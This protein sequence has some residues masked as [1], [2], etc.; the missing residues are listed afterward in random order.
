MHV[1]SPG[2]FVGRS[3]LLIVRT[4]KIPQDNN[5]SLAVP[6][7]CLDLLFSV[8]RHFVIS[9]AGL[10][11]VDKLQGGPPYGI[12]PAG[13]ECSMYEPSCGLTGF[14]EPLILHSISLG[15]LG[16]FFSVRGSYEIEQL[17]PSKGLDMSW[18][19]CEVNPCVGQEPASIVETLLTGS[20]FPL[21]S[22]LFKVCS[23]ESKSIATV[24][25]LRTCLHHKVGRPTGCLEEA[26]AELSVPPQPIASMKVL[27]PNVSTPFLVVGP[28][29]GLLAM[30]L[31]AL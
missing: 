15:L 18:P 7:D 16:S 8:E 19:T 21:L 9:R 12:G 27:A 4:P 1:L 11:S 14:G 6:L 25:L 20:L 17:L 26:L 13:L 29:V 24:V 5:E 23:A 10:T 3:L 2:E 28:I 30:V 22:P 31:D